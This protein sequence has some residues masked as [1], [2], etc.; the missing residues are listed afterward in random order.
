MKKHALPLGWTALVLLVLAVLGGLFTPTSMPTMLSLAL[1]FFLYYILPGYSVLLFLEL[2]AVERVLLAVPASAVFVP[3]LLYFAD[4]VG[5]GLSRTIVLGAIAL[6]TVIS[7]ALF[8]RATRTA[9]RSQ[10]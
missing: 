3:V 7:W 2:D 10:Q 6:I 8:V 4:L 1:A 5:L 9:H